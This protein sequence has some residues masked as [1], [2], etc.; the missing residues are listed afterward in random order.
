MRPSDSPTWSISV[1]LAHLPGHKFVI[2][3]EERVSPRQ[4]A[5]K[6]S[7]ATGFSSEDIL[8]VLDEKVHG[9]NA[10][11]LAKYIRYPVAFM[12]NFLHDD[13]YHWPAHKLDI[14]HA[15]LFQCGAYKGFSEAMNTHHLVFGMS[16]GPLA[17]ADAPPLPQRGGAREAEGSAR[18]ESS[19]ACV[20]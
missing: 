6:L 10:M 13:K 9:S 4:I 5:P 17:F 7:M 1:H 14:W 18:S 8:V 2:E 11:L 3:V 12:V 20:G 15:W 19:H 16:G